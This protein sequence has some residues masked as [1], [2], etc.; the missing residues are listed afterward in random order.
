MSGN[1]GTVIPGEG[2][3][4]TKRYH[5]R[6]KKSAEYEFMAM[7]RVKEF[8]K[9]SEYPIH[10]PDVWLNDRR[11]LD[12]QKINIKKEFND[13]FD[14]YSEY[15]GADESKVKEFLLELLDNGLY[16]WDIEVIVDH[17]D[18]IWLIDFDKVGIVCT[19]NTVTIPG[20]V[21]NP[22]TVDYLVNTLETI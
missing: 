3:I 9:H 4:V 22:I 21:S 17:E 18:N 15:P 8:L 5:R 16:L 20:L 2:Q 7:T 14:F 11:S 13:I 1:C 19:D 12:M 6:T 10:I